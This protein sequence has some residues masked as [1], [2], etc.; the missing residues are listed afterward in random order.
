MRHFK[1]ETRDVYQHTVAV[2]A[3]ANFK[4]LGLSDEQCVYVCNESFSQWKLQ[5]NFFGHVNIYIHKNICIN[6]Y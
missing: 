3:T 2:S 1:G 4:C 5:V 6:M